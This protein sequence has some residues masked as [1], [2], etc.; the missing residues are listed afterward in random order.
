MSKPSGHNL[1]RTQRV[2]TLFGRQGS[3]A[4]LLQATRTSLHFGFV[5][6]F[7]VF[8]ICYIVRA[9]EP[10]FP[11]RVHSVLNRDLI[12]QTAFKVENQSA[13]NEA[14]NRARW[15]VPH[16]FQKDSRSLVQLRDS[17]PN[18]VSELVQAGSY[19]A[20]S[21]SN[22]ALWDEFCSNETVRSRLK[23]LSP[24]EAYAELQVEIKDDPDLAKFTGALTEAI[25]PLEDRGVLM[26]LGFGVNE[27]N[28]ETINVY[29]ASEANSKDIE[30][31]SVK[32]SEVLI[33]DGS[34]LQKSIMS[35]FNSGVTAQFVYYYIHSRLKET[36]FQDASRTNEAIRTA[37]LEVET[38]YSE[39]TP[40]QLIF[41]AGYMLNPLDVDMLR[42]EHA[43]SMKQ[44]TKTE[45]VSRFFGF[46]LLI[47]LIFVLGWGF[48][49]RR[50]R[51]RPKTMLQVYAFA[52][53]MI[54][55]IAFARIFQ[56]IT[57]GIG[58]PELIPLLIFAQCVA[59]TF[60]WELSLVMSL[61][62]AV[63]IAISGN[64]G[65]AAL[66]VFFLTTAG[67]VVQLG[68]LRTRNKLIL[69]GLS[70]GTI[71]FMIT[72]I[73]GVLEEN[74]FHLN[75]LLQAGLNFLWTLSSGFILT[76]LL[77]FIERPF[78]I[79]TDMSLLELGDASHPLL[80]E[81]SRR[82][83]ATHNHSIQVGNIAE[84]ACEAIGA[85]GLMTR[86]GARF[87]DI[88][89][90]FKPQYFS[91]NQSNGENPHDTLE[92]RMSTLVIVS[93]VKDG[94]DLAEQYRLPQPLIDL[95]KQHHGTSLVTF[96]FGRAARLSKENPYGQPVDESTFRYPGPKPQTK[97]AAILMLADAVESACRS[98]GDAPPGRI[99]NM[100]RQITK[101]KMDD[102]Q[103]DESNLTLGE[104][105]TIE[106]SIINTMLVIRHNRIKYPGQEGSTEPPIGGFND[107]PDSTI[108]NDPRR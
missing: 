2:A 77:P 35:K 18:T 55:T 7:S 61:E 25:Q 22:R 70:G 103:F 98:L 107:N 88:G 32:V 15:D 78:G 49:Y 47:L 19:E 60:S 108:I 29:P 86:I 28:Q 100:V 41:K 6:L 66:T 3:I 87:H 17:L 57:P 104:L 54:L 75:M 42:V 34:R 58:N 43:E 38:Q 95:I 13:T 53:S 76:G 26:K 74:T 69:V 14:K 30:M 99:E 67:V 65:M 1:T 20:L 68:R 10:P 11:F 93:H 102:G 46:F 83:P 79:L 45:S 21:D 101:S 8:V 39:F 82:A 52:G 91:E 84:A 24:P 40:G 62:L 80:V 97:E 16:V 51:R 81:L 23:R 71:S 92:P 105:R 50:E 106:N 48:I 33:G 27:G 89:K 37:V 63:I 44:R 59:I 5:L 64:D 36:L 96:F 56:W 94:V 90:I 73:V 9:W 4:R 12:C 85:R 72:L 31:T